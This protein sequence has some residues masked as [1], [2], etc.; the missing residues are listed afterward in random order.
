MMRETVDYFLYFVE[1]FNP[2]NWKIFEKESNQILFQSTLTTIFDFSGMLYTHFLS[3][4]CYFTTVKLYV[5]F[6][7][8]LFELDI[9]ITVLIVDLIY[10]IEFYTF[11]FLAIWHSFQ[12]MLYISMV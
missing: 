12:G 7:E 11:I 5:I 10:R 2:L 6:S 1:R 3:K 8:E 9:K 4:R